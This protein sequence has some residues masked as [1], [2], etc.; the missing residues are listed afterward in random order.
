MATDSRVRALRY[1]V[2]GRVVLKYLGSLLLAL[3]VLSAVIPLFCLV[4]G[5][6]DSAVRYGI[7]TVLLGSA[8]GGLSR[9]RVPGG[10]Q[11]NEAL[12]VA[13]LAFLLGALALAVPMRSAGLSF[14]DAL[15]EAVS[16]VTTTGLSVVETVRGKPRS[17]LFARAWLQWVG[18]LGFLVLSAA[19]FLRPGI[20]AKRLAFTEQ[21]AEDLVGGTRAHAR[22]VL[23]VYLILTGAGLTVLLLLGVAPFHAAVHTLASVSTGGFSS[24]D[25]SLAEL[26]RWP[27]QAV[28][29]LLSFLGAV[30]FS[31]YS[32]ASFG[33]VREVLGDVELRFLLL[34]SVVS[35]GAVGLL[36]Y[37][38]GGHTLPGI[39]LHAPALAFS[40]QSTTGFATMPTAALPPGVKMTLILAMVTGGCVGSTAGGVKI[41]R[42]LIL[43]RVARHAVVSTGLPSHAYAEP[44]LAGQRLDRETVERTL[45]LLLLFG[46]VVFLSWLPFVA[47]GHSPVDSLFEVVSAT[48]TVGLSAGLA[49]PSLHPLLKGILGLDMLLGRL[50]IMAILVLLDP[51]TWI[52]RRT[53]TS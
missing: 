26:G 31:L 28:A 53:G 8:G 13:A 35:A 49:G 23:R 18:G 37:A 11:E 4:A 3:S 39:L 2:R 45:L 19:L 22:T 12:A 52:G 44:R 41:L 38:S 50:E 9:L 30:S 1:S 36:L 33:G 47:L 48:G 16:G 10:I 5:E 7:V 46:A 34:F 27:A 6:P 40:A 43:F 25:G 24:H 14:G 32:R 17:F 15:F 20:V 29:I 21:E 51:G 42:V